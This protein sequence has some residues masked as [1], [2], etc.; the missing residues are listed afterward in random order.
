MGLASFWVMP[1]EEDPRIK[2]RNAVTTIFLPGADPQKIERMVIRPLEDELVKVEE[3]KTL[4]VEIR[5]NVAVLKFELKDSVPDLQLAWKEVENAMDRAVH[6]LPVEVGKPLLDFGVIDVEAVVL[7]ITGSNDYVELIDAAKKIRDQMMKNPE[8]SEVKLFGAPELEI[9]VNVDETKMLS[10]GISVPQLLQGIQENNSAKSSGLLV[11]GDNRI[12][13]SQDN[14]FQSVQ[15]L[16]EI[17]FETGRLTNIE[18]GSFSKITK[19]TVAPPVTLFRWNRKKAV[20]LGIIPKQGLNIQ[21]FGEN[22]KSKITQS[23]DSIKPLNI[24]TV[25][26][27]PQRTK[28]R[29]DDLLFSLFSGM[30]LIALFLSLTTSLAT[31]LI[32]SAC[33]P[34]ISLIGL[35]IY[36]LT[37]GVLHQISIAAFVISIGQFIDNI[38]VV[39]DSIQ[40]K[41]RDGL[42]P[43]IASQETSTELRSP[44]A[45][46]TATGI[47]AFLPMLSA[48]GS[49]ADF[50][51]SLPLIAI[52]TLVTSYFV[53]IF[54]APIIAQALI[55]SEKNPLIQIPFKV[56]ENGFTQ[57]ALGPFWRVIAIVLTISTMSLVSFFNI[58][59]EFFPESDRNE[60][61]FSI[62]LNAD[63]DAKRTDQVLLQIE[64]QYANDPRVQSLATFVGGDTP[65]F[66]YNLPNPK[67]APQVGQILVTTTQAA[68]LKKLGLEMENTFKKLYPKFNFTAQFL[69]QG[70]PL[71]A[72]IEVNVFSENTNRRNELSS[73]INN[74]LQSDSRARSV[75]QD[76]FSGL[77]QLQLNSNSYQLSDI[78]LT[79]DDLSQIL[80]FYSSGIPISTYRFD[81]DILPIRVRAHSGPYR[82]PESL[83]NVIAVRGRDKDYNLQ[84]LAQFEV[85]SVAPILRKQNGQTFSRLLADL[86]PPFTFNGV[87]NDIRPKI[88]Q[89]PLGPNEQITFG[90]DAKGAGEANQSILKVVPLAM[91]L[92][93]VFLLIEFRSYRKVLIANL[94]L[95]V[96]L[97]GVFPGLWVGGAAFGFMSLLGILALVGI[98]I[99]NIILLL[100]AL[101]T[102]GSLKVAI[103]KRLRAIVLTTILTLLGLIPLAFSASSLWPPLAW[104]MISGLLTGTVATLIVVPALYRIFFKKVVII[105]FALF[106]IPFV[107]PKYFAQAQTVYTIDEL[108]LKIPSSI[109][110]KLIEVDLKDAE[111][112]DS[113]TWREAFAPRISAGGSL[114][115][116]DRELKSATPF[117]ELLQEKYTRGDVQLELRQP[118]F[119]SGKMISARKFAEK[120]I[121]AASAQK[122]YNLQ[123]MKLKFGALALE[124]LILEREQKFLSDSIKNIRERQ[125]DAKRLIEKGRQSRSDLLKLDIALQRL[126]HGQETLKIDIITKKSDLSKSLQLNGEFKIMPPPAVTAVSSLQ[127]NNQTGD[128]LSFTAQKEA[129]DAKKSEVNSS[130]LPVIDG[131]ARIV[132]TEGRTLS[133]RQWSEAGI[134]LRWEIWGGGIRAAQANQI[135]VQKSAVSLQEDLLYRQKSVNFSETQLRATEKLRWIKNLDL[136]AQNSLSNKKAEETRYF[137]GRGSLNDL[138]EADNLSLELQR[139]REVLAYS[140]QSDCMQLQLWAGKNITTQCN[141]N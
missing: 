20:G 87:M 111:F 103:S 65:R 6:K 55:K 80:A 117:G 5:L 31:A 47:C 120:N 126:L 7:A 51:F 8:V 48:Q 133:D 68:N 26:F 88:L 32:V 60:F 115:Q 66:Y 38:I 96:T 86:N 69:Q 130:G 128:F 79:R 137:E 52:I 82:T 74:I 67:S 102:G 2:R 57:I 136:L 1:R 9:L 71:N 140:L 56:L 100:E 94:A 124:I 108:F 85:T 91:I 139:D 14:D 16:A 12:L 43:L 10:S 49:T 99:N 44:M 76:E 78:G 21:S 70:P 3:L 54:F 125:K 25:A 42:S 17:K 101:D 41:M 61:L 104:T 129:I 35:F 29:I 36:Y 33:V 30:I 23:A 83:K 93:I 72:K 135:A 73:Q 81:R 122:N 15:K 127:L 134:E 114:M 106:I 39:I 97:L 107:G 58:D 50:I 11:D 112:A 18:L 141:F 92:L 121:Q 113:A 138:I 95:P 131:F 22:L 34:I 98:A 84:N 13:L 63:A 27:Q 40:A 46:A 109:D 75:R 37:G 105:G 77:K 59:R 123:N 89:I 119:D 62:E 45:F 28:E 64:K 116:R 24:E 110:Q 53:A 4:E 118:L 19:T 90:G 132:G